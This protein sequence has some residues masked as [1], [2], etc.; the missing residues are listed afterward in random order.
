MYNFPLNVTLI[1]R[2]MHYRMHF[3]N[4]VNG[5][6]EIKMLYNLQWDFLWLL[7]YHEIQGLTRQIIFILNMRY[8]GLLYAY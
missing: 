3:R 7:P 2:I 4:K 1:Q 5:M 8:G 6:N